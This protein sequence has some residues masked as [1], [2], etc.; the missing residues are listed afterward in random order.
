M[1]ETNGKERREVLRLETN[2]PVVASLM[3]DDGLPVQGRYGDQIMYTIATDG[4]ERVMYV[5]PNVSQMFEKLGLKRGEPFRIGKMTHKD[6]NRRGVEWKVRRLEPE[7]MAPPLESAFGTPLET[8]PPSPFDDPPPVES[9]GAAPPQ[10]VS[11]S[12]TATSGPPERQPNVPQPITPAPHTAQRPRTPVPFA[13]RQDGQ[14]ILS[15]LVNMIDVCGAVEHYAQAKG[16]E[17]HFTGED[18]RA[19]AITCFINSK[20]GGRR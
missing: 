1:S 18:V 11:K 5:D 13:G 6:G 10:P 17:L 19:L 7:E 8:R 16:M 20:N 15:A 14:Y 2:V 9:G 3:F 12:G 4:G